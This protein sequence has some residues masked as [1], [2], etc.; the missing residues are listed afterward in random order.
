LWIFTAVTSVFWGS[1]IGYEVL[2]RQ[3]IQGLLAD[4]CIYAGSFLDMVFGIWLLLNFRLHLCYKL[5][6]V[7]IV[8]YSILLSL[9]DF[10]FWLHP[11]GPLTK[12][13]PIIALLLV[14]MST[15]DK[16]I[17]SGK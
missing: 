11:F 14:L 3:G 13:I 5:Q 6:I 12:N 2:A 1:A 17:I 16:K 4:I 10:S 8:T 9:I 7:V 15:T